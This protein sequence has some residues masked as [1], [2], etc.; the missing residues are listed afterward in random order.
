MTDAEPGVVGL[1]PPV[2]GREALVAPTTGDEFNTIKAALIPFACWRV[3][4]VRFAFASS[5]VQ[6]DIGDEL[7]QLAALVKEHSLGDQKPPLSVFGHADP[8]GNDEFNKV[9]SGRRAKAI[10]ALLIRDTDTWE[11][12]YRQPQGDDDWSRHAA[13]IML[14][15]V[16]PDGGE[17][18]DEQARVRAFQQQEGLA[19]DGIVGPNTRRRLFERYMAA[20]CGDFELAAGDFLAGGEDPALKG[21]VQ[22]CSEFNPLMLFSQT[23]HREFQRPER[24]QE[25][26]AANSINRRVMILLFRPGTRVNPKKWPCPA[27]DDGVAGCRKRFW[28]DGEA[29]RTE[30]LPEARRE[31]GLTK[32]TFACRFYDRL[33]NRSPCETIGAATLCHISVLLR[34]NSGA[35]ALAE[36]RYRINVDGAFLKGT[37]DTD[38]FLEHRNVPP[39]EYPLELDG[40]ETQT[41]LAT[42]PLSVS[43]IPVRVVGAFLFEP[44]DPP[45]TGIDDPNESVRVATNG[46]VV[47]AE[48]DIDG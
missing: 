23:E 34:S 21:D 29:R 8:V 24:R 19:V 32:D 41:F 5:F 43:R 16:A 25:R 11:Q 45:D 17:A 3:N 20:L 44:T 15:T 18:D 40:R 33:S 12:L 30:R 46:D 28:S 4:D 2:P 39:G 31:F 22:G 26:N 47:R 38:G 27:A 48:E 6:P 7:A 13:G 14:D 36:R 42:S 35:V 37:T 9:L 1:H 10:Y